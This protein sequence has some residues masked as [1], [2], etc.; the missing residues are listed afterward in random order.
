MYSATPPFK[1]LRHATASPYCPMQWR[2]GGYH[3]GGTF[4]RE[5]MA[6]P[7]YRARLICVSKYATLGVKQKG[8]GGYSPRQSVCL[9]Q[10][11]SSS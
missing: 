3:Q 6:P 1:V 5:K 10:K 9:L 2:V 4:M 11:I 8:I 7:K